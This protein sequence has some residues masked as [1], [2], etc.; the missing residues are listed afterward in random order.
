MGVPSDSGKESACHEGD[1]GSVLGLERSP[2]EGHGNP[3][4]YSR[5]DNSMDREA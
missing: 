5:L 4:Q 1:M 3:H 2:E